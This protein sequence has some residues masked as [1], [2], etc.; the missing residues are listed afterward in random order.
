MIRDQDPV[1]PRQLQPH[2]SRDL[3]TIC[4]KC[5]NKA[6]QKRYPTAI[7]L[8]EDLRRFLERQPILARRAGPIERLGRFIQ[9]KPAWAVA[10]MLL[11]LFLGVAAVAQR[12]SREQRRQ[13]AASD[14]VESIATADAQAL[15]QLLT[16][17][18]EQRTT[19]LPLLRAELAATPPEQTKWVNLSVAVLAADRTEPADALLKYLAKARSGEISIIVPILGARS[20]ELF[21]QLWKALLEEGATDGARLRLACLAAQ[22]SPTDARWS[23][24]APAVAQA[25]VHQHPLDIGTMSTALMPAHAALIP[26]LVKISCEPHSEPEV[27]NVAVGILTRFAADQPQ[28]LVELT[29]DANPEQFRLLL[30]SLQ[31]HAETVLPQ[32]EAIAEAGTVTRARWKRRP[33]RRNTISNRPTMRHSTVEPTPLRRCGNLAVQ[34]LASNR[35]AKKPILR[36]A[37]LI[38]LLGPL[39]VLAAALAKSRG[40]DRQ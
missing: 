2:T 10:A 26:A 13:L 35:C 1:P 31:E 34:R 38:E 25:L 23:A 9:R 21:E 19:I 16:R 12:I 11:I 6:P 8:A 3:E 5:L 28:T 22:L 33:S 14:L 7:Q 20:E 18:P 24:I 29:A 39:N 30:P 32:L 40:N 37:W 17:L 36:R 27:K 15:P 4:L